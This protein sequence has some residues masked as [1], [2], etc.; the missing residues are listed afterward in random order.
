MKPLRSA[1]RER[2]KSLTNSVWCDGESHRR[3]GARSCRL[4]E[5]SGNERREVQ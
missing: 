1:H 5:S 2:G 3:G 4:G